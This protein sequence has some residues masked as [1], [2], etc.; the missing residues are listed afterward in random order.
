MVNKTKSY[1]ILQSS[2]AFLVSNFKTKNMKAKI[3]LITFL[4]ILSCSI[5]AWAQDKEKPKISL[6]LGGTL[7]SN[8]DLWGLNLTSE[9][10]I[11]LSKRFSFVP[12]ISF[13]HSVGQTFKY[14]E[15]YPSKNK[16]YSKGI[17]INS[18]LKYDLIQHKSGFNLSIGM[19]PSYQIGKDSF[20]YNSNI[21]GQGEPILSQV[22]RTQ[23]RLLL[24][25]EIE[26]EWK[27][28]NSNIRNGVALGLVGT[29]DFFPWYTSITYKVKF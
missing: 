8:L 22:T 29:H 15:G 21:T 18:L 14:P 10:D 11:P 24:K 17:F 26:A 5:S 19:G 27:T 4:A 6:G 28:K 20:L 12:G 23:N 25:M 9:Y 16:D 3:F 7:D 2:C 1:F 13:Y